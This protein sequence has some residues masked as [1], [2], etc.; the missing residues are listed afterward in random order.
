MMNNARLNVGIQGIGIAEHAGQGAAA[1]AVER[2]QGGAPGYEGSAPIMAHPDVRRMLGLIKARTQA[3]RVLSL[4]ASAALDYAHRSED[5]EVKARAQRRVDLLIPVVKGWST[6]MG[7][8][9]AS[10]GVQVHG[11][12]GYVEETGAAQHLRD[13]RI[14]SIYEGTTGIQALDL[15]GRKI[16]RD[17]GAALGELLDDMR[18]SLA[19]LEGDAGQGV[20]W[21]GQR[22]MLSGAIESLE[23]TAAWLIQ[24]K[25]AETQASAFGVLDLF[26][27]C[28]GA[29]AMAD[30]ASAA[31]A[32]LNGGEGAAHLKAKLKIAEF[33]RTQVFPQA[34]AL[35]TS[36][37]AGAASILDLT[38]ADLGV[39]D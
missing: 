35:Q 4:R 17:Q 34:A 1:Y 19:R 12:M 2:K 37:T 21:A 3:A 25:G 32:R 38:A 33:Y 23:A 11:G 27:V 15:V 22:A 31:A 7:V 10:L 30:S 5:P 20:D 8:H 14:T 16:V 13:V 28:L 18:A 29:W 6:E 26:G 39:D 36:I 24:A 9:S